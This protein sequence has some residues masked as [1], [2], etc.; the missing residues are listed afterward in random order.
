MGTV[1]NKS[2]AVPV[3]AL[4]STSVPVLC[5]FFKKYLGT[6]TVRYFAK[7]IVITTGIARNFVEGNKF[8]KFCDIMFVSCSMTYW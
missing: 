4:K 8:E 1:Q 2:T 7:Y 3:L 5:T 6:G